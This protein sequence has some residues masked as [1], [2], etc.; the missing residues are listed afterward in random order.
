MLAEERWEKILAL[1]A[2]NKAITVAELA[3]QLDTSES[4]IR[5]DLAKLDRMHRLVRTRGGATVSQLKF[6]TYEESMDEKALL[7]VEE[8]KKIAACAVKMIHPGDFVFVDAGTS[9]GEMVAL[10]ENKDAVYMTN[11]IPH[12]RRLLAKG[13]KVLLPGGELKTATEAIIGSLAV[14]DIRRFHFTVC[15]IGTNGISE[16]TGFTTPSLEEAAV[17]ETAISQSQRA[18]ILSD[19]SKF[20]RVSAVTFAPFREVSVITDSLPDE[21]Y[22]RFDNVIVADEN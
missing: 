2:E 1:V 4:T 3:E 14:S 12:A 13:M 21:S 19:A 18:F 22:A 10:I 8:K 17:K 7:H 15:F 16:K 5:R 20:G 6:E 11:S 9:T